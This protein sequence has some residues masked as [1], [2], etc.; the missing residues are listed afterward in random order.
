L[1]N[2]GA[3]G[4][5]IILTFLGILEDHNIEDAGETSGGRA[6]KAPAAAEGI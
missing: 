5:V 2:P 6:A 3:G 1:K 4:I